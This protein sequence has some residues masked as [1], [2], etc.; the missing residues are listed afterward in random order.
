VTWNPKKVNRIMSSIKMMW[1]DRDWPVSNGKK[2]MNCSAES[3]SDIMRKEP[4]K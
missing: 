1:S 3:E 2:L 4:E